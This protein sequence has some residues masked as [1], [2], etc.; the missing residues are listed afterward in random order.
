MVIP[1]FP[2]RRKQSLHC[3]NTVAVHPFRRT[4]AATKDVYLSF[5]WDKHA[6]ISG[7][8]AESATPY[9]INIHALEASTKQLSTSPN[10]L[11]K[12]KSKALQPRGHLNERILPVSQNQGYKAEFFPGNNDDI[13]GIRSASRR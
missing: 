2:F 1:A 7:T 11:W 13:L 5:Y 4:W 9:K 10:H 8:R 6:K 12:T 3:C